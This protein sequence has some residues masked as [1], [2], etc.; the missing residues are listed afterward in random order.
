MKILFLTFLIETFEYMDY[1]YEYILRPFEN[2]L[3]TGEK[4]DTFTEEKLKY[5]KEANFEYMICTVCAKNGFLNIIKW[6]SEQDAPC[7]WNEMDCLL[8]AQVTGNL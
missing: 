2:M 6:L 4:I 1:H 7:P 8:Q 3:Q 5:I